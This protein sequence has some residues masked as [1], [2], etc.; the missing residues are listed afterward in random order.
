MP[1]NNFNSNQIQNVA[2]SPNSRKLAFVYQNNIYIMAKF[3]EGLR[4]AVQ[5]TYDGKENTIYNGI[6]DWLYEEEILCQTNAIWWSTDSSKVAYI[7]FNDSRVN[8]FEFSMYDNSQYGN[9]HKLRYPK[10][11]T[12]NPTAQ[13]LVY[14][15]EIGDTLKLNLPKLLI[16]KYK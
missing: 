11:D 5:I 10:P 4:D 7:K 2:L 15:T 1:N 3:F 6:T 16:E 14:N 12:P 13:V 8:N 9:L